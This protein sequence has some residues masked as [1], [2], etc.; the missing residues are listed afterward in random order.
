VKGTAA[1]KKLFDGLLLVKGSQKYCYIKYNIDV[2]SRKAFCTNRIHFKQ[3]HNRMISTYQKTESS[4]KARNKNW[5]QNER[6][7]GPPTCRAIQWRASHNNDIGAL[8]Y[9]PL[10]SEIVFG[11]RHEANTIQTQMHVHQKN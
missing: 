8:D 5:K 3:N 6:S 4:L 2:N 1:H 11:I 7:R 9:L 10:C